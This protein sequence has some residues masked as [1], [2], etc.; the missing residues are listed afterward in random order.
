MNVRAQGATEYTLILIIVL[1]VAT[2]AVSFLFLS[3]PKS[4][5]I[6]IAE[7]LGENIKFTP[8]NS[9]VPENIP[10]GDWEWA[11]YTASGTKLMDFTYPGAADYSPGSNTNLSVGVSVT[12][13]APGIDLGNTNDLLLIRYK[14]NEVFEIRIF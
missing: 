10:S 6:G 7:N 5:I 12:F 2:A 3:S 8:S 1:L 13:G 11:V 14:G 4:R 9:M